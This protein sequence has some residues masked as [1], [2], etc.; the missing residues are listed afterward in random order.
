MI[1]VTFHELEDLKSSLAT[2]E[3]VLEKLDRLGA[4]IAAI[5][6]DAAINQ[7]KNNLEVISQNPPEVV[8]DVPLC[9]SEYPPYLP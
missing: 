5:H 1:H 2:L 8:V 3:D 9:Q 6:V 4:G 7:L